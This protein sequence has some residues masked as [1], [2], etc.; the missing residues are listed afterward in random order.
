VANDPD[1]DYFALRRVPADFYDRYTLPAYIRRRLPANK[2]D[3]IVDF[4]CGFGHVL[5]ALR[6]AG[7]TNIVGVETN[8]RA[9]GKCAAQ[10]FTVVR[11]VREVGP[12]R[13]RFILMSHVLEHLPKPQMA[14]VLASV[15]AALA[16]DGRLLVCVPNAQSATGPYWAYEDFTHEYLFTSGSLYYVLK[17]SGFSSIAFIDIDCTEGL[18]LLHRLL[19]RALLRLYAARYRFW[20][21]VTSSYTHVSSELIFSYEIKALCH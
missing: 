13:A 17:L 16:D 10:G 15:K 5:A 3:L 11:D 14:G 7:H 1:D 21:R 6:T 18:P 12:G 19:K 4:G 2:A 8:E 9:I 20:N